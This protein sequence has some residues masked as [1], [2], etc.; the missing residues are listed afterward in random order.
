M[1]NSKA[2]N[3][4]TL[5][6]AAH[7]LEKKLNAK[8]EQAYLA[9]DSMMV[10]YS[11]CAVPDTQGTEPDY[12]SAKLREKLPNVLAY[13][14]VYAFII[15]NAIPDEKDLHSIS[16]LDFGGGGGYMS[17][18]A[19]QAGIRRVTYLDID[20]GVHSFAKTLGKILELDADQYICG[21]EKEL[22]SFPEQFD[23]IVS[24][25]VL[26]HIYS[27]QSVMKCF[28]VAAAPNGKMFHQTGANY[29]NP[30]QKW[31]LTKIQKEAEFSIIKQR[32][33]LI[34]KCAPDFSVEVVETLASAT[35]GLNAIDIKNSI[36]VYRDTNIKP[37]PEH[38]TNTCMLSGYWIERFMEPS[39]VVA[40]AEKNGFS[41]SV[42][43]SKW[44]IGRSGLLAATLKR[45]LNIP[46]K[47]S[48]WLSL[49]ATFYYCIK[50]TRV[51]V[52]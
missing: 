20:A 46:A 33:D 30:F 45:L 39:D 25:D 14:E 18:L 47:M 24:S 43:A 38:A 52:S 27:L 1:A 10:N 6:A 31:K 22:L 7:S 15:S 5:I 13:L 50:A 42:A 32:R 2:E 29:R 9:L 23:S 36:K 35:R 11:D 37:V 49:R 48:V 21:T 44:G 17:L 51:K 41:A 3:Y 40:E 12:W 26:E 28:G 19:K 4:N 34:S 8:A 16:L